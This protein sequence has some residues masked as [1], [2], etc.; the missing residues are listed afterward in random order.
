MKLRTNKC[1][2]TTYFLHKTGK[3]EFLSIWRSMD[4]ESFKDFIKISFADAFRDKNIS[5]SI[6]IV[7]KLIKVSQNK[8]L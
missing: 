1:P 5:S 3:I 2:R 6:L 8:N 7:P 4:H